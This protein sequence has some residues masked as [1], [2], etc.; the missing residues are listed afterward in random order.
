[1]C[2]CIAGN[3]DLAASTELP[4]TMNPNGK[5][6]GHLLLQMHL[7]SFE[8]GLEFRDLP[9]LGSNLQQESLMP[10]MRRK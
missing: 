3:A 9:F 4:C 10:G 7:A 6:L 2:W 8:C 1:M 5:M